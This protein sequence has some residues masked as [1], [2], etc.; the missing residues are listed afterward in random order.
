MTECYNVLYGPEPNYGLVQQPSIVSLLHFC[1][2]I[3]YLHPFNFPG[4]T[5]KAKALRTHWEDIGAWTCN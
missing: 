4:S 1:D 2:R 5:T 3:T